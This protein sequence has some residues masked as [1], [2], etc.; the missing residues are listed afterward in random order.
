MGK[1]YVVLVDENDNPLGIMEKIKAH[2]EARLHRAVSV[3][4]FNLKGEWILQKRALDKY[5]S[6]GLWTNACCTH[7]YPA[8]SDHE[9]ASRRLHEEMGITCGIKEIFSFIY[10]ENL[11]NN[12]TEFEFDHVFIGTTDEHPVINANEV[13]EWKNIA[14]DDLKKDIKLNPGDYTFWFKEIFEKVHDNLIEKA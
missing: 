5:H 13:L 4:I 1:T 6:R 12:L 11:E 3:F 10:K 7:P 9:A 14:Y 8:E 2:R